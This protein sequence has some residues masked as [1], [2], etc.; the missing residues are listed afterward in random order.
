MGVLLKSL[1][2]QD[3]IRFLDHRN[4]PA[5]ERAWGW[6]GRPFAATH[7]RSFAAVATRVAEL[8]SEPQAAEHRPFG[9]VEID[10]RVVGGFQWSLQHL[11]QGV[12][13]WVGHQAG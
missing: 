2:V 11:D 3:T 6:V 10:H 13:G 5:T 12:C 4:D 9:R 1:D 8:L 7:G